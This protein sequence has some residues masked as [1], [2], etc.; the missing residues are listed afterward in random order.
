MFLENRTREICETQYKWSKIVH[1]LP[2]TVTSFDV[3]RQYISSVKE[4]EPIW[5]LNWTYQ[6]QRQSGELVSDD[7]P[8]KAIANNILHDPD[9]YKPPNRGSLA[10][11]SSKK[12]N[13]VTQILSHAQE[14]HLLLVET[15]AA[16]YHRRYA[17]EHVRCPRKRHVP[18]RAH[19]HHPS[20]P[21]EPLHPTHVPCFSTTVRYEGVVAYCLSS[22]PHIHM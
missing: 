2:I 9:K 5:L 14:R 15:H 20:V 18:H 12:T 8:N 17:P 10:D 7:E 19:K 22:S 11:F 16:L 6:P 13:V 1:H 4:K 21:H 3:E